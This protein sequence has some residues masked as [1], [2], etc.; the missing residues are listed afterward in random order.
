MINITDP[1][2]QVEREQL[3]L[4]KIFPRLTYDT[5]Y[6]FP[7]RQLQQ[8][9]RYYLTGIAPKLTS[10][11][12]FEPFPLVISLWLHPDQRLENWLSILAKAQADVGGYSFIEH[13][14]KKSMPFFLQAASNLY[15]PNW[16]LDPSGKTYYYDNAEGY[17]LGVEKALLDFF[18]NYIGDARYV[19]YNLKKKEYKFDKYSSF[20]LYRFPSYTRG[21]LQSEES[22]NRYCTCRY[23][24]QYWLLSLATKDEYFYDE[25]DKNY[26]SISPKEKIVAFFY[27]LLNYAELN[28][29]DDDSIR[30]EYIVDTIKAI[31]AF[32]LP[33]FINHWWEIIK[34][35]ETLEQAQELAKPRYKEKETPVIKEKTMKEKLLER[36]AAP[37]KKR[38]GKLV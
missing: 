24:T 16:E 2:W 10:T 9:K 27:T 18:F 32:D 17:F 15:Y 7:K 11:S 29:K 26:D 13:H 34:T 30:R 20:G 23:E 3:W 21:W 37:K 4:D 12:Q 36:R 8:L 35:S 19:T 5:G 31:E 22:I 38:R 25:Y 6:K 33:D 28:R 14:L 1:L